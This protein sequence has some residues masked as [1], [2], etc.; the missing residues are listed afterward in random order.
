MYHQ[1][2]EKYFDE[3]P[4]EASNE[5]LHICSRSNYFPSCQASD[6][7]IVC[8]NTGNCHGGYAEHVWNHKSHVIPKVIWVKLAR[9]RRA[10]VANGMRRHLLASE[11]N[12]MLV[13]NEAKIIGDYIESQ[14]PK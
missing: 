3:N 14:K 9:S 5:N 8:E 13:A 10:A 2:C 1:L 12:E 6:A 4:D 11:I 7:M